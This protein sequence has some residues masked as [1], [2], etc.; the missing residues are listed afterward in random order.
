MQPVCNS[1]VYESACEVEFGLRR[2]GS[3]GRFFV[4][5]GGGGG[6]SCVKDPTSTVKLV[7]GV[8]YSPKVLYW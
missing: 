3:C 6:G 4:E 8:P 5:G 7:T 1:D 2:M